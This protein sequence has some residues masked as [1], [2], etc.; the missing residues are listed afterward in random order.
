MRRVLMISYYFPPLGGIGS[1]R[2]VKFARYLPEF[3]WD[4]VVITPRNGA[5]YRDPT[6]EFDERKVVRTPSLEISRTAKRMIGS[7]RGDTRP[8]DVGPM[9]ERVRRFAARWV[10]RPDAQ[11]GWY[12]FAL[13]SARRALRERG[14]DLI[15]SSSFPITAHLVAR[16]LHQESR[17]PWVAEFRDLWTDLSRYDSRRRRRRDQVTERSLLGT[18]TAVVTVS[19][20]Y[21]KVLLGRG[22]R[23][24]SVITNGFDPEDFTRGLA[25]A[26]PVATYMGTYYSDRQ[27]LRA[28][29]GVLGE[30]ARS[31]PLAGLVVR[32]VGDF[33]DSLRGSLIEAG[34]ADSAQ[35]TG[36]VPHREALRYLG[37]STLLLL[38]GPVSNA[39]SGSAIQGNIAAKVFEYLGSRR[40]ILYVGDGGAEIE[41]LIR[42]L[43]GVA[44]ARPGDS[45]GIREAILSLVRG[46]P[47]IDRRA[48]DIYTHRSLTKRL[49]QVFDMAYRDSRAGVTSRMGSGD[50]GVA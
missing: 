32:F 13:A 6:L 3:G 42:E 19:D 38:A 24:V 7:T 17:I 48:L 1:V 16:R 28:A 9:M 11:V 30:L 33:P 31:G 34:L 20:G 35:C 10:Y 2:A 39:F 21:A 29:L 4:P 25:S 5:Y 41:A 45:A 27:D 18:S 15:F 43:P 40:P 37:D 46:G 44:C 49:A 50:D 23:C 8:A 14:C 47:T 26:R 36:F 22:A 12:P